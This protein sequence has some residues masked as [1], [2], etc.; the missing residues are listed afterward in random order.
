[1]NRKRFQIGLLAGLGSALLLAGCASVPD[2][3]AAQQARAA[4]FRPPPGKAL[5]Y[6]FRPSRLAQ[7]GTLAELTLD[8]RRFGTLSPKTYLCAAVKPGGHELK[9]TTF[10]ETV[11]Q[12]FDAEAD[13]LY[14]FQVAPKKDRWRL[15][16]VPE[17]VAREELA[18]SRLS[19]NNTFEAGER[20]LR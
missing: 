4:G 14:F 17:T 11:P 18:N 1:M 8:A 2:A 13:R 10:F 12:S 20:E 3:P 19:G 15:T 16:A 6:V 7:A 5:V 9:V